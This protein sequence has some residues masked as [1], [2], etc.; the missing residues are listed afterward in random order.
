M[1][2]LFHRLFVD[3]CTYY[4][5][6]QDYF[7]CHEVLE[8]YWKEIAPGD[9]N[10]PLVGYVQLATGMYHWRRNNR[11]GAMKILKKALNNFSINQSSPFF[12]YIHYN[13]LYNDCEKSIAA[14]EKGYDFTSFKIEIQNAE[15][16]AL[17]QKNITELPTLPLNYLLNKHM[18][19]DRSDILNERNKKL[20]ERMVNSN[21]R[22][23]KKRLT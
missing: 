20:E 7:E 2:P 8:E 14:I 23:N 15:L 9:K 12:D 21:N 13:Q 1:H 11:M 6:N 4:N 10:H 17:V 19:R 5:G 16:A 3:F 22:K 18:L